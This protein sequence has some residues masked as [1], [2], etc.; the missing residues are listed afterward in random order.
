LR[1]GRLRTVYLNKTLRRAW[2]CHWC[3]TAVP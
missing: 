2:P 1:A 3:N